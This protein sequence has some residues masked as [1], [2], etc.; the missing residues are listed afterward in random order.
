MKE[1]LEE[2]EVRRA[3]AGGRRPEAHRSPARPWQAHGEARRGGGPP[4]VQAARP[5]APRMPLRRRSPAGWPGWRVR[6][7]AGGFPRPPQA[8]KDKERSRQAGMPPPGGTVLG[9]PRDGSSTHSAATS[10]LSEHPKLSCAWLLQS[11]T[12]NPIGVWPQAVSA[13]FRPPATEG[14]AW[15][16]G[17]RIQRPRQSRALTVERWLNPPVGAHRVRGARCHPLRA[18]GS[19][20]ATPKASWRT[21]LFP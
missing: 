11:N 3:G 20:T 4:G 6:G 17:R 7:G 8:R 12:M 1:L 21:C 9:I 5:A 16:I 10:T 15:C 13:G 18:W 2:L 19:N 14:C